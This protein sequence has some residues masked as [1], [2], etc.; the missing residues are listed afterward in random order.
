M[1]SAE[2]RSGASA[3]KWLITLTLGKSYSG[4]ALRAAPPAGWGMS[5]GSTG[6]NAWAKCRAASRLT[7]AEEPG[8]VLCGWLQISWDQVTTLPCASTP[9]DNFITMA[10]P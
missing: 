10:E 1:R 8:R 2:V 4:T 7:P 6:G 9:P 3:M 5:A